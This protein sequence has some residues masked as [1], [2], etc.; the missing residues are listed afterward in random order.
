MM[1]DE[2]EPIAQRVA[3]LAKFLVANDLVRVRIERAGEAFEVG[4]AAARQAVAMP[5]FSEASLPNAPVRVETI[6]ADRVGI[7][8][9]GRPAPYVG[10]MFD[11]DRELGY[12]E[13][14]GIRNPVRS[15]GP[16]RVVAVLQQDGD[17][18]DYGR[19]LFELDRL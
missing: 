4:R 19:P 11:G 1:P 17:V 2:P 15:R 6:A 10:E 18:V 5:A 14:L 13:Q 8:R 7:F 3:R 12:V 9:L 16:G